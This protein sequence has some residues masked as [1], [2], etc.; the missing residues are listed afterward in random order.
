MTRAAKRVLVGLIVALALTA[1][2]RRSFQEQA[3]GSAQ[4]VR[5]EVLKVDVS[6]MTVDGD[7]ILQLR[8]PSGQEV[9][10]LVPA[11]ERRCLAEGLDLF[12][13]LRPGDRVEVR[14]RVI[15]QSSIQPCV[16]TGHYLRPL[17]SD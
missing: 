1:C 13:R 16:D 17:S 10:V 11:R 14:G 5:G 8:T 15:D 2:G 4:T 7:G 6:P 9:R 3:L 12:H